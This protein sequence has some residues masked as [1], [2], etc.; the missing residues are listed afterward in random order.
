MW[1]LP[2]LNL[3]VKSPKTLSHNH[4]TSKDQLASFE[5]A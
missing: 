5:K 1:L 2:D 3:N 4:C